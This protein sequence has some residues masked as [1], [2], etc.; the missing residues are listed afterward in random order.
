MSTDNPLW[1]NPLTRSS[2]REG[3]VFSRSST[4]ER[5]LNEEEALLWAA[6]EKLP[7][8]NRLRTSILKDVSGSRLEQVDLS[9]LGVE[10]KQ[11]IVQTIIGIGEE[12]NELF[13]SKLRDR[14]DRVGL[15]LPEIEVRFK[16]LHV[17]AHVHVGSRALPTLW[18][19]TLNWIESILDMVRLVP[20]RKR[21]LTVL[22]NI[23]GII[24]PS[25]IT[26]L[27]G[28]P[29]SGRTTFLLALSG[30]LRDDLKVTG[31]V[32]Y[33]GHELHEF[34][35][36][37][38]A[39]YTSQNDV[40]LGELTVRETFDFS[41]RCQGVGSS[42]EMLSE[43]AKRE[44]A[45]G[46][47]PDPDI[48]AF[49]KASAIQGQRTSIVSD[50][51]LKIL[52]LDICGDI[53]VGNDMLRGISGGQKK[54]V[55]TGEMLVGPVKAF[56]MDE[57]STGLDSSTTY[58]IVKCLKQSVH[59][60]SG[61]M[62]ISLL[63][64]APETY[65]LF[66]DVILLSEG[67]I[68]YQGPRTTVLEFFEAQGFRCPERKG[69]ADFLQEVTSRKDQSQ[70]WALD[71]PYSYV[72][73]EDFVEAFKKFSVGQRLV[74][75]LSRPFDKSTSHPAALVTEKFSL[76]NWELF[77]AC[78][79]REW[80]LMRRNS[81]LFIF[82]AVQISI[83][84]VIGMT[85]F[86]RTEMHHET[87]GDGNK[88][89]GALFYGLLNVAF[90]GMAEMAMTVVYL[91]VF[92]KQ[93]D[94]LF[95]PAW[96]YA[97]PV[98][99]LKIPVSV[100]DSAIWTVITYYVIGFAPEASRFFK[101]FLLFI[102]LHIMSLGL[103]RMVGALSRTIVVANT[104]GSFQ[105][106]L[107]CAL[108]GFI[109]SRENIPNWLT[110]G[111]WSTP[112]SYAQNA[113]SANE[114]L[115]HRWQRP[116]NSSDTVGVAFLKSRGLFP[117]EYWYWIGVGA[118]LG[119][120]AVYNFL[121]IVAL[122]Y[123]D[124]FQ[125]S[126]GAI[127]EEKTKDKDI[128]VSEAS[129]T[130]DS[131]EGIEM[132]LATKT[133][134]VLPFPPLSISFSHVN[135]YVDMPLEM[136]KQGVSDDKLQLLQDITGAFR[137]GV[138]TALVGVSGAGKTTLM[139]VL[140]GRKT[141]GYIEGSVNISGFPKK[142]ET[143]ARISGYCE[144]N[145]IHSP[146]VTVRESI[147]YSAWL[148]LSQEIDSRTRKMFVQ[149]VLNLVELT[150]VQNGLVGLPGVS[151]LSTEQRKRLTIAVELVANPSIIFMDEPTSGLD[152]RAAAVVMRAV[153]NTV[154]TGRTV[155]C[156][157]HQPSID[158]FEM[159]DELL[160]MKR[161]GQVIYAGPLGT[162]SCHLIE[163][164]EAV[165][166]IPK[167]GD[168]I[169]PAT[170][171]LDVTSQ[172]VESQL[173]ID[174]ATIYKESSLY[175]RNEDLVEELSTPA[176]GSKDLYFTSTF[177]QTFVEQCKACLWKQY[178]SYWRNPQY[179]LVRLCF[180]AF[181]SLM[182]GVIFWG[183]GSKR[184]TQQDVFNVTGVLYLVVLFVGVNNAASVIPVVDI[185][186]TVYYRERAAGMYSPLPYAIAQVV[187][188][189][190]YLLTQTVI[191]GLV[192]YPM[193]QFEWTVVKFFW[194]M[195][196]SFFSFWYFTLYGMMILALSPNGQFAAI[197]S[198]FFYIMWNLFSGFLIP[199]SQIPVWWQWYY[200]ISPVAWTLYG[201]ITSQLGD[202]KSFMQIPEQAPVRV[203]DFIRD[204]FNFR[205]DF[206]GLMAG[207]HVAFV[208]LSILV[209]AFC[210]KHF[211]FQ[212]R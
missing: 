26:L 74:S 155:V 24:K 103:F 94:L 199:Y 202:V 27:L 136:K 141:G 10:H 177:S 73:V 38:T 127:S 204:R 90:N 16:R 169:N 34:V 142:Q 29:G 13:L 197:I 82:K 194:F 39:S 20:T 86:L 28:P 156:T 59:A 167:I 55:T 143:F 174:F 165:E 133:G 70:Y 140:A 57:I 171:M 168:G 164:L 150:P 95:Y 52:G 105:F 45:T 67:Q 115:A 154:K 195:F 50:Y 80:L 200:W 104:L 191:F 148:R 211:N 192:V 37:R 32:T 101:Q 157:I 84:S 98:I 190:P 106:L 176:P 166:G 162:N 68:V 21:S 81:F 108:G 151:G 91:P 51:V 130:W 99:L 87:V 134:M 126:R 44:R 89:L 117:N 113:L 114:F 11:R 60:T 184:D 135:Y 212:R 18:N 6:L 42:Y 131:V 85:V 153:R 54:R 22:N 145:D 159:F 31:S 210:I 1:N 97:L 121:Y 146:Y 76:T 193:V 41:S 56:F 62:V 43:L 53:F 186:R 175:K 118:L 110:W 207:V 5:Q 64:P 75:E 132:A 201:L 116:S 152:A 109:L 30:K 2:R 25:R 12:D 163:Y 58:Q 208:I 209:F 33:N 79:A 61:T 137:P 125:N 170:W 188:E 158:I 203:E 93:R 77:Q 111:Y 129:K 187:I 7:T 65:D 196:F 14:I 180:T 112:L 36:Q 107:M 15:K 66:D 123:L 19:T 144:Q 9:K 185:E 138:L 92:Y 178:W 48:D 17:V 149:E 182:F 139:D 40:H 189:V 124:P 147:T 72:S 83:I 35:P 119:F 198:S 47:K 205:Y 206:L 181:V 172:T 102:C 160:L 173:R 96:A 46:I 122:S 120:G 69:V 4:R 183:C 8:Y 78:L 179:Q 100:M 49:M 63:Q 88:Y 161:G 71:E 3:T 128:S 23:S